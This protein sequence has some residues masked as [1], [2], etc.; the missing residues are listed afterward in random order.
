MAIDQTAR[1]PEDRKLLGWRIYFADGS[2]RNGA[3]RGD[4]MSAPST[5]V[6]A[7]QCFYAEQYRRWHGL[8]WVVEN[9]VLPL[10]G[11]DYFWLDANGHPWHGNLAYETAEEA[12]KAGL[13]AVP[14]AATTLKV[15]QFIT[16]PEWNVLQNF[17]ARDLVW[18]AQPTAWR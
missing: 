15:G 16:D 4:W 7:V 12:L 17:M 9:Y 5:G 8:A 14:L 18:D 2:V 11:R 13:K 1:G 3:K 6:A 10:R